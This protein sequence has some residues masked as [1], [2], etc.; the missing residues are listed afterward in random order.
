MSFVFTSVHLGSERAFARAKSPPLS[1]LWTLGALS[2]VAM[3]Q[4]QNNVGGED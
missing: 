1:D 3:G 4:N 2:G